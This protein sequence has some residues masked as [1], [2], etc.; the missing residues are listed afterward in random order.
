MGLGLRKYFGTSFSGSYL[1]GQ[2][3]LL[4]YQDYEYAPGTVDQNGNWVFPDPRER[5]FEEI[6]SVSQLAY[7]YKWDWRQFTLDLSIGGA[8]YAKE[9]EKYTSLIGGVNIGFPFNGRMFGIR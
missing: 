7:G 1:T 8:F 9:D 5:A 3:D 6:L 4:R 2:S